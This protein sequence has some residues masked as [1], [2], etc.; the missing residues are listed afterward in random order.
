[1][2]ILFTGVFTLIHFNRRLLIGLNMR[3]IYNFLGTLNNFARIS[4]KSNQNEHIYAHGKL[5]QKTLNYTQNDLAQSS[6]NDTEKY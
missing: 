2:K 3:Y 6:P 4:T 5:T 1:M